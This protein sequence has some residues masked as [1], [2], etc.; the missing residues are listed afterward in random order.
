[1]P[2][3]CI[4]FFSAFSAWSILLSR[5]M[6]CKGCP[7]GG[8]VEGRLDNRRPNA[9]L[10]VG[11]WQ[12]TGFDPRRHRPHIPAMAILKIARMGHPVL[13]HMAEPVANPASPEIRRLV[14]D[15]IET[16]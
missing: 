4:F 12:P 14:A 13:A 8:L 10:S 2:S 6:I 7:S 11:F 1:M 5:T 16:M 3:L 15:M 9:C